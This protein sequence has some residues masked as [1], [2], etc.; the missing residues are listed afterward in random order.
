[1]KER[2]ISDLL[3]PSILLTILTILFQKLDWDLQFQKLFYNAD[4]GWFLKNIQ[5]WKFLYYY[6]NIP[7]LILSISALVIF[8]LGYLKQCYIKFRKISL[9]LVLVMIFI[10]GLLVNSILK[11]NW[12]RP[13]PRDI[14][15]FNGKFEYEKLLTI[16][17]E[18]DGKSF[19]CGHASMGFYFFVLCYIF[20]DKKRFWK[21][22]FIWFAFVYGFLIG[23]A[24]IVQGGHFL[25][26]VVWVGGLVY[27]FSGIF[28]HL[29]RFDKTFF[30]RQRS[31]PS[32]KRILIVS[33]SIIILILIIAGVLIAT[34]H[35]QEKRFPIK[36]H[37]N[38]INA[39]IKIENA[40]LKLIPTDSLFISMKGYGH[41]FPWSKIETSLKK[42]VK[43]DTLF[44]KFDEQKKGIF[45]ELEMD[46]S[47]FFPTQ[48]TGFWKLELESGDVSFDEDL[49][50]KVDIS[51][52]AI[53]LNSGI[54]EFNI[55]INR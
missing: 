39:E 54:S 25:S 38:F 26:D 33:A 9:Y 50:D 1:M 37:F 52:D 30:I 2:L 19:P 6:G 34:P 16:D 24:R 13:R 8:V 46:I 11:D 31:I 51:D 43:N 20:R 36:E 12:G 29:F 7:A 53:Y 35:N 15:E 47:L 44:F 45:T 32:T 42:N 23:F 41:G 3:L 28:Y 48:K 14:V 40:D 4:T 22:F 18:S 49:F 10:P 21:W 17:P 55:K 27:I 5:P